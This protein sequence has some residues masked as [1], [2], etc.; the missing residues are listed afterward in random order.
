M[1]NP[2]LIRTASLSPF[3]PAKH[4]D[5]SSSNYPTSCCSLLQH[6][7]KTISNSNNNSSK[8]K[9]RIPSCI[10]G[11]KF[12]PTPLP[13]TYHRMQLLLLVWKDQISLPGCQILSSLGIIP[14]D[15]SVKNESQISKLWQQ[16]A[17]W[18]PKNQ[19]SGNQAETNQRENI[20]ED[21]EEGE[22]DDRISI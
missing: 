6:L 10:G 22:E 9:E 15:F 8:N 19:N 11:F 7:Y 20:A 17:G 4:I 21:M 5:Y 14:P 2:Q 3:S 18:G 12:N 13:I 16:M 1:T